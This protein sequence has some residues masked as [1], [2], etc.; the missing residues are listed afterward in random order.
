MYL[1]FHYAHKPSFY[2]IDECPYLEQKVEV[3][4]VSKSWDETKA[5]STY[6][7]SGSKWS[8][9]YLA[10]DGRDA[11]PDV[12]DSVVMYPGYPGGNWVEFEVSHP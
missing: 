7:R 6:R 3:Y 8:E 11:Y 1:H 5:T 2:T 10:L 9:A 12:I 4:I